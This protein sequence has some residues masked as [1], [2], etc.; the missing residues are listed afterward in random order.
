MDNK[1]TDHIRNRVWQE[2]FD[3]ERHVQYYEMLTNRLTLW[4][5]IRF[6]LVVGASLAVV[7]TVPA[8]PWFIGLIGAVVL[9][10]FTTIDLAWDFGTRAALSHAISLECAVI[11]RDY[12]QLWSRIET[13]KASEHECH[14]QLGQ[15]TMRVIAATSLLADTDR[16]VNRDFPYWESSGSRGS[17]NEMVA[18]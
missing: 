16:G 6:L 8:V 4:R 11:S 2:M 1:V 14:D 18:A 9:V 5:S 10:I 13:E 17:P 15:L 3:A 12:D 7:S